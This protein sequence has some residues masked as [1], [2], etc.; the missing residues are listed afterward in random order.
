MTTQP[1]QPTPNAQLAKMIDLLQVQVD[2]SPQMH[3]EVL[4]E[5]HVIALTLNDILKEIQTIKAA[6]PAAALQPASRPRLHCS[7]TSPATA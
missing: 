3:T 1:Q 7:V 5:L 6:Q 2:D 4:N